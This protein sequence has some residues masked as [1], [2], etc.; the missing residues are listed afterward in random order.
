V[1]TEAELTWAYEQ[2]ANYV[3]GPHITAGFGHRAADAA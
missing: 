3:Q 2:G 1:A